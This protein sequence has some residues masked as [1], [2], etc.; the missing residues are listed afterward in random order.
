MTNITPQLITDIL[1]DRHHERLTMAQL[2]TKYSIGQ[3]QL[4]QIITNY[5]EKYLEKFPVKKGLKISIDTL[6]DFWNTS[7]LIE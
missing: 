4:K 1:K 7:E 3:K 6:E 2:K 5:S